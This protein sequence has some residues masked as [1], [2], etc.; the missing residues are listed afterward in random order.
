MQLCL[1]TTEQQ[2][3]LA[4]QFNSAA[5]LTQWGGEGFRFPSRRTEFLQRLQLPDT[6]SYVLLDDQDN[7]LAF[8]QICDRFDRLHLARLLVLPAY[9]GQ[10]LSEQ[11]ICALLSAGLQFWPTREASLYVFRDN[12]PALRSYLRLGFTEAPQP[13]PYRS[14]LSFM[15]LSNSASRLLAARAP[16][17]NT[18][19]G[20][21]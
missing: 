4:D 21:L 15:T 12:Q 11:L 13:G 1:A 14:D 7:L 5:A 10:R 9:R 2:W 6:Q 20:V 18:P 19:Q 17:L 16:A 3:S 8:G